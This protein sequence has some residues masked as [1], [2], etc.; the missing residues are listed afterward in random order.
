M[1][2]CHLL[3]TGLPRILKMILS[4]TLE[5]IQTVLPKT[6]PKDFIWLNQFIETTFFLRLGV[7]GLVSFIRRGSLLNQ[8]QITVSDEWQ[9]TRMMDL[10][11]AII[12][13]P[14]QTSRPRKSFEDRAYGDKSTGAW[15]SNSCNYL[16]KNSKIIP[17]MANRIT[18][19]D[20]PHEI[21]T[22]D[23]KNQTEGYEVYNS[24]ST[25]IFRDEVNGKNCDWYQTVGGV[26]REN[27]Y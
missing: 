19:P 18:W 7:R 16:P 14:C 27:E 17:D 25:G 22:C 5:Y 23:L 6:C 12:L 15:S 2:L 11:V 26:T 9:G 4:V 20:I 24:M 10:T 8:K 3:L 21:K 13:V 1:L